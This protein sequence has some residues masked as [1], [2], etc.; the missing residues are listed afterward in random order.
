MAFPSYTT[1]YTNDKPGEV[2]VQATIG[3]EVRSV[4]LLKSDRDVLDK[5]TLL[6]V[7][8]PAG[9]SSERSTYLYNQVREL[10]REPYPDTQCPNPQVASGN[11]FETNV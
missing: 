6:P 3:G 11:G 5:A 10:V 9:L 8:V 4:K 2:E 1:K 7:L